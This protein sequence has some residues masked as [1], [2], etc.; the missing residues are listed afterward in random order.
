MDV[1]LVMFKRDG[2]QKMFP[3]PSGVTVIGRR[4]SCDLRIPLMSVSKKHCQVHQ[5]SGQLKIRD[6]GSRNGIQLNGQRVEEA[7]IKA[8]DRLQVGPLKFVFQ[9]DGT[10]QNIQVLSSGKEAHGA[11]QAKA[12]AA[13]E[14]ISE[15]T[16]DE[17]FGSFDDLD[18]L[19][20]L[21]GLDELDSLD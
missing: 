2:G 16:G 8:G 17:L 14:L 13:E 19:D 15:E 5:D 11:P 6:L 18:D 3:L 12:E 20:E 1:N 10:P 4:R 21:E 7:E 9:I